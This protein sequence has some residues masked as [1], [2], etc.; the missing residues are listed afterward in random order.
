MI[1]RIDPTFDPQEFGNKFLNSAD[2]EHLREGFRK[3][4]LYPV[5]GNLPPTK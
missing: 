1:R 5:T 3:A 4:E 2:L